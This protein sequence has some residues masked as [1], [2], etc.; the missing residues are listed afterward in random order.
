VKEAVTQAGRR[1][2]CEP[3]ED[4]KPAGLHHGHSVQEWGCMFGVLLCSDKCRWLQT[5][6]HDA[7]LKPQSSSLRQLLG[8]TGVD[9]LIWG[10][11]I[12]MPVFLANRRE[13]LLVKS[14]LVILQLKAERAKNYP[15]EIDNVI[16]FGSGGFAYWVLGWGLGF[17]EIWGNPV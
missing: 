8:D 4:D 17:G 5:A 9:K 6:K 15:Q 14:F 2:I 1:S 11:T 12:G 3:L 16:G 7:G 13:G 10:T